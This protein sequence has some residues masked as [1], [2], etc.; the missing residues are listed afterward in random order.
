V[1]RDNDTVALASDDFR[2]E[3]RYL[4]PWVFFWPDGE[5]P[6]SYPPPSDLVTIRAWRGIMDLPTDVALKSTSYEGSVFVRLHQLQADWIHSWPAIGDAPFLDEPA[7]LVG[8]EFDALVFNTLHGWYRQALGC[9]RNALEILTVAAALAIRRDK[10][11]FTQWRSGQAEVKF[12]N[13]RE[14]LRDSAVGKQIEDDAA[15]HSVFGDASSAWLKSRYGR[16]CAYAHSEAGFNN[17]DF[18]RS[19]GPILVRSALPVVEAE[20]RETLA[21]S[22]LLVRISWPSY[23]PGQGQPALLNGPQGSW[24]SYGGVLRQWLK[25]PAP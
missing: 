22:Y 12:G 17:A 19:N 14:L 2:R 1:T 23:E 16:L 6:T 11:L 25:T 9:L 21:L 10:K 5:E 18:W 13:A 3:R 8:E 7:L 20:F 15:P 4:A 24:A